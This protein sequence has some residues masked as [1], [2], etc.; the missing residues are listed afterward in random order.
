M[1]L[2]VYLKLF[3]KFNL[4][5]ASSNLANQL[6]WSINYSDLSVLP[7]YRMIFAVLRI[8]VP[9]SNL[10]SYFVLLD[11]LKLLDL[12]NTCIK[13]SYPLMKYLDQYCNIYVFQETLGS[14]TRDIYL[15]N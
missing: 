4:N 8:K 15:S 13:L 11:F 6:V 14:S 1:Y 7:D 5:I 10:S 12:S 2:E 9:N 3:E